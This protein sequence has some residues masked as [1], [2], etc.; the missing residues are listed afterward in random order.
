[1][2]PNT[3]DPTSDA[4]LELKARIESE[5][6]LPVRCAIPGSS[7]TTFSIGGPLQYLVEVQ[8]LG[9]LVTLT[10]LLNV[11]Q[12]PF[13]I[14][15]AG[16]NLLISDHGVAE[17]ILKAGRGLRTLSSLSDNRFVVG[18]AY[19]LM[20][21]SRELSQAGYA[22]LEFAGGIPASLGGAV[23]MNAGAH[24]SEMVQVVESVKIVDRHGCLEQ[25]R[26]DQLSWSYRHSGLPVGCMLVEA[27]L[28]L[29]PGDSD[30]ISQRRAE[31]LAYRKRTQPLTLPSA[32]SVFKNPE[33]ERSAG[34]MIDQCGLKGSR[35]GAAQISELHANWIVN[36]KK[37][38]S[39]TDVLALIGLCQQQVKKIFE[40]QIEPEL[41]RW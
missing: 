40:I 41:V 18:A 12:Q 30:K 5:L 27:V 2:M 24:G 19:S 26:A 7:V 15:G 20:S 25:I 38:A 33:P 16:S 36:P 17:W 1:M 9:Q 37:A 14:L 4:A 29:V 22:G 13:R 11:Y 39:A 32:G 28:K 35:S 8:S 34:Y 10:K 21:L 31:C 23:F 3:S 6:N